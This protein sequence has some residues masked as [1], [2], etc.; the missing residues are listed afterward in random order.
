MEY[1]YLRYL[2]NETTEMLISYDG[3]QSPNHS[4]SHNFLMRLELIC[5]ELQHL[6]LRNQIFDAN[7][8]R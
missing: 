5:P 4:V 6:T 7:E 2:K 1:I 3:V 8:V